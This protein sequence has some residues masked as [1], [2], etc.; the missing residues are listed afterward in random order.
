MEFDSFGDGN[1]HIH[2]LQKYIRIIEP[3]VYGEYSFD[4]FEWILVL[5]EVSLKEN[6]AVI[7]WCA[8]AIIQRLILISCSQY[9]DNPISSLTAS[10]SKAVDK[11]GFEVM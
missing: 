9:T 11:S 6:S 8:A 10:F 3:G 5:F 4:V 2:N 7:K 1:A